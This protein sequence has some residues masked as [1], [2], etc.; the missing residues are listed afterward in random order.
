MSVFRFSLKNALV[1]AKKLLKITLILLK[2]LKFLDDFQ[3]TI[4]SFSV[5]HRKSK[6]DLKRAKTNLAINSLLNQ[7]K[8]CTEL[9]YFTF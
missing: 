7:I 5:L 9:E 2:G 6:L 8:S 1:S 4:K 3:M